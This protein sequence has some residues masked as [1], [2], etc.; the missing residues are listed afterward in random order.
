MLLLLIVGLGSRGQ[1]FVDG[2][3]IGDRVD[4]DARFTDFALATL[5][6]TTPGHA[7]VVTIDAYVPDFR[8][9]RW[10]VER[11]AERHASDMASMMV[12]VSR[13]PRG[14]RGRRRNGVTARRPGDRVLMT[15]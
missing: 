9:P 10:S 11:R 12:T 1:T 2:L 3:P 15:D 7:E 14:S 8:A 5:D 4:G 6:R 13:W